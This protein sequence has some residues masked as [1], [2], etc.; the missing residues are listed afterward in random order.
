MYGTNY[1]CMKFVIVSVGDNA[2]SSSLSLVKDATL[3]QSRKGLSVKWCL[4]TVEDD[5]RKRLRQVNATAQLQIRGLLYQSCTKQC[6]QLF[7][8][9]PSG[10]YFV[11]LKIIERVVDTKLPDDLHLGL[12]DGVVLCQLANRICPSIVA[13]I[14]EPSPAVLLTEL[15]LQLFIQC[16]SNGSCLECYWMYVATS[17]NNNFVYFSLPCQSVNVV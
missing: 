12:C 7:Y 2:G 16:F 10:T 14:L 8:W 13:A 5:D 1:H 15:C 4:L 11:E 6:A 17:R 9:F 3:S